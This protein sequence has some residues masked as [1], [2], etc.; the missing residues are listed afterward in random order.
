MTDGTKSRY[1][2]AGVDVRAG[3]ALA[4]RIARLA[5]ETHDGRVLA[6]VGG[7]GALYEVPAGYGEPVLVSGADGVGTKIRLALDLGRIDGIGTDLVAMCVNDIAA[8]GAAPLYFLDYYACG[9]LDPDVAERIVAG[10]ARGCKEAGCALVGGETAEM[11]LMY[12]DGSVDLAGFAVGICEK[13]DL[14]PAASVGKGD[15]V[16]GLESSGVHSN[17]YSL[18]HKWIGEG[19]VVLDDRVDGTPLGETLLRPTRIY[20]G[21]MQAVRGKVK[22]AAH[23]TGGGFLSNLGRILPGGVSPRIDW[24]KWPQSELFAYLG[25]KSGMAADEMREVFN[26]GI[27]MAL[28]VDP[29]MCDEAAALLRDAGE[30]VHVLGELA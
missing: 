28:A 21:A 4:R 3:D 22:G 16:L 6:G 8:H 5:K 1:A 13:R 30:R 23:I 15:V 7:F 18:V 29:G 19:T 2:E 11:P 25:R 14:L 24:G 27:G 26:C 20:A 10:I 17:G 12:A 9:R